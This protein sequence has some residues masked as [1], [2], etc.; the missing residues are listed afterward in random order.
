MFGFVPSGQTLPAC[1]KTPFLIAPCDKQHQP[2]H[3]GHLNVRSTHATTTAQPCIRTN[4]ET[5]QYHKGNQY[6]LRPFS[7]MLVQSCATCADR[8]PACTRQDRTVQ[9]RTHSM[10]QP[11]ALG[12]QDQIPALM[13]TIQTTYCFTWLKMMATRACTTYSSHQLCTN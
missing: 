7:H 4:N 11:P 12:L 8:S 1:M 9:H 5:T 10:V 13:P 3:R 2:S 6:V